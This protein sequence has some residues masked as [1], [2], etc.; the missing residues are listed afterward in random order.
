MPVPNIN[1]SSDSEIK[2]AQYKAALGCNKSNQTLI[3]DKISNVGSI[4][5]TEL[6]KNKKE[7]GCKLNQ[8]EKVQK[9]NEFAQKFGK[10]K[11]FT[12][13][14]VQKL[15]TYLSTALSRKKLQKVK[16][17]TYDKTT[18]IIKAIPTLNFNSAEKR[19][20]LKRSDRRTCTTKSLGLGKT[21]KRGVTDKID[22]HNL[23][24]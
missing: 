13:L 18:G 9:L 12:L 14:E 7:P 22:T 16:D 20:T 10:E 15:Q 2:S 4:L 3:N 5:E 19:F 1:S 8:T 24:D 21:R 17:V 23:K 11:N 6:N